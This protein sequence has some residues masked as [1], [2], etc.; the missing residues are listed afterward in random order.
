[1]RTGTH[2]ETAA[3][4]SHHPSLKQLGMAKIR[5]YMAIRLQ[6]DGQHMTKMA[7]QLFDVF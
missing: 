3:R 1:M 5:D 4:W 2:R 6:K 7:K